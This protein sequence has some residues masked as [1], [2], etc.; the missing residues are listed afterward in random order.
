MMA[1]YALPVYNANVGKSSEF[2][3]R[4]DDRGAEPESVTA[5][6][7]GGNTLAFIGLE[8]KGLIA[9][10]DVSDPLAPVFHR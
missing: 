4:S 9:I 6:V 10:Y 5:G 8:R 1:K 3:S 2:E 7:S